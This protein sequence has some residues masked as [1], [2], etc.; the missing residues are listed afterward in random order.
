[1]AD[2][3]VWMKDVLGLNVGGTATAAPG[4]GAAAAGP[5]AQWSPPF[6]LPGC[7]DTDVAGENLLRIKNLLQ[8]YKAAGFE[9]EMAI[10]E[11][12]LK[13]QMNAMSG[14]SRP[15]TAADVQKLDIAALL[16]QQAMKDV[17]AAF[18]GLLS[19]ELDK[20][21][22]V[23]ADQAQDA[24]AE[25]IHQEFRKGDGANTITDLKDIVTKTKDLTGQIKGYVDDAKKTK[26]IIKAAGKLEDVSKALDGFT[27]KLKTAE[28][29]IDLASDV[30]K[31]A[32]K[33]SQKPSG[34]AND[35]VALKA[36]ID[37]GSFV[38]SKTK[39]PLIGDYWE[40][41]IKPCAEKCFEMLQHL[42][43]MLETGTRNRMKDDWWDA[44]KGGMAAPHVTDSGLV[45]MDLN[46]AFPSGQPML[47][48]MWSFF[49]GPVPTSAPA[50]V[51]A[52]FMK[53]RKQY[54]AGVPKDQQLENDASWKNAWDLFGKE[55]S[56]NLLSWVAANKETVWA[57]QYG[58]LPHP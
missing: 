15:L 38:M 18:V 23:K 55:D 13:N 46:R 24:A 26:N 49:R 29:A 14:A 6:D 48:F 36:A 17:L 28:K 41:V 53:F 3:A 16:A 30:A 12:A 58:S 42:D 50:S 22:G 8:D 11:T 4:G 10:V 39:V 2:P 44:V 51:T 25:L 32:G 1:M 19:A 7:D 56:P 35:I 40:K 43:D 52:D 27:S 37:I 45:G 33:V 21:G 9:Q 57:M 34:T 20:Y 31:L 5:P 47:D 54:N